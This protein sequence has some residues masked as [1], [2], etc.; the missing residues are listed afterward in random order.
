M[1]SQFGRRRLLVLGIAAAVAYRPAQGKAANAARSLAFENLHTGERLAA[2]Y[3]ANGRYHADEM[4]Q[5]NRILRDH[6][7]GAVH[8]ID[9]R[10]LDLLHELRAALDSSRP[11]QVISAYRS[12]ATNGMLAH[13]STGVARNSLHM[14]GTAIDLRIEDRPLQVLRAAASSLQQGG[15]GFY[16]RSNFV[17]VDVGRVRSW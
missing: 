16:P 5:I 13:G 1:S 4:N 7:T 8:A 6:R 12:P 3:W 2:T 10:L 9:V 11:V 14:S 17:H 15:V